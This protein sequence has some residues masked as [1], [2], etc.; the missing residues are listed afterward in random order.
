MQMLADEEQRDCNLLSVIYSI[1]LH[2]RWDT[3]YIKQGLNGSQDG[4]SETAHAC[5][6]NG[7]KNVNHD[8]NVEG[9][10]SHAQ[11]QDEEQLHLSLLPVWPNF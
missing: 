11:V 1:C 3:L 8:S 4:R 7:S 6:G 10:G 9:A 2:S 5:A